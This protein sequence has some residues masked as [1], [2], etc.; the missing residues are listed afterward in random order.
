V[1]LR[2]H[3]DGVRSGSR[4]AWVP[5]ET[6]GA[7][8]VLFDAEG[9]DPSL[10]P[11]GG[12]VLF[13]VGGEDLYRK[14]F[15]GS[16][17][18]QIWL[19]HL[20]DKTFTK[21]IQRETESRTP[22]WAP[23][24]KGF[25]YVSGEGGCMNVRHRDLASGKERPVTSF[26]DD[27]VIHP[28]LSKDGR[29]M[30]FRHLF[31]FY[32]MD[33]TRPGTAPQ[34]I[35]LQPGTPAP[36]PTSRRRFYSS[37]WNNDGPGS[38]AFCDNGMQLAFTAGG[39]LWVMDTVLRNPK[40]VQGGV[41]THERDCV[42]S[43]DGHALYYFSDHGDGVALW[44]AA[45]AEPSA[46]WWENA[47]FEKTLLS[48][49]DA[50]RRNLSVSPDGR[51]LA[52]VEPRSAIV[53]ADT[54]GVV[55][56]C[57]PK[58][59]QLDAYA[60]SPDGEWIVAAMSDEYSNS[61]VWILS[62]TGQGEPYNLSRHFSWDGAPCW[63]PDGQLIAFVGVRPEKET[64]LFY[65]WLN[66]ADEDRAT[67]NKGVDDARAAMRTDKNSETGAVVRIDFDDLHRRVRRVTLPGV[68]PASP[69]FSHDSRT[70]AFEATVKGAPG[71]YTVKLPD[72]LEPKLLTAKRGRA[73][74][75]LA[76]DN[77][78]LW[79]TDNLPAHFEK[80]FG[81]SVYQETDLRDY[82]ELAY[83][84]AW[85]RLRDGFCDPG[86][87]GADWNALKEKY[88]LAARF[89]PSHSV[90]TRALLL[91]HGELNAS[92]LGFSASDTSKKEWELKESFQAW[93]SVTAHLGL[94]FDPSHAGDGWKIRDV[95]PD[96]PAAQVSL[97]LAPGDL[98][99][100]VDGVPVTAQTD[101]SAVLNGPEKRRVTLTVRTREEKPRTVS[102]PVITFAAA[103]EK[104]RDAEFQKTRAA[105]DQA[106]GG[107]FGYLNIQ[108]MQWLDYYQFEQEV[109]SEGFGKDGLIIDVRNN[110]GGFVADQ[111]LSVLCGNV[112]SIAV[113]R[114]SGPAYLA[115]Y[116]GRP[117][118]DKPIV[119]L[120]S[121]VTVSNGEIFTHAVKTLKRGKVVGTPTR[122]GVIATSDGALLDMGTL[123]IPHRGWFLLDGTD[124][125]LNG[126]QPDVLVWNT[127]DDT[128]AGRDPQ[129]EA[130]IRVMGE[131]VEA[132]KK[133][134]PPVSLN[135]AR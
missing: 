81:F 37:V 110:T 68:T 82:Q 32:R 97:R 38:V 84:T 90:F 1:I 56:A 30:V 96:T 66:R 16:N 47:S 102:L 76:K 74:A 67:F 117:V 124:M 45:R 33:P 39:D 108:K 80:T 11:E 14:G 87:H 28:A 51:R 63:S 54:N 22:L 112:H 42:F 106:S 126:A 134:H 77:R 98:V 109:F 119:V 131:E 52:W 23:D 111:I 60:W 116:W 34:R 55:T 57:G 40:L 25:Y 128:V 107:R 105:V 6:R 83:L 100:T 64:D 103:R 12:R 101:P 26:T 5:R 3:A 53:I 8:R 123:R 95:I 10:S 130:A 7:E 104:L 21:L 94:R 59:A 48:D 72:A 13:T 120:C 132:F 27:S 43:P 133:S 71:T 36:R 135:Y 4:I 127:P 46:Y 75:W 91:L 58:A 35:D 73:S 41:L 50:P 99:L 85:G 79:T 70:L 49:G 89:A 24:G 114:G 93:S 78:L 18:S 44:K 62:A 31:D 129:L 88:R 61:D 65:V 92:H 125:E 9:G 20:R 69:F 86:F 15:R 19:Y 115:G 122:G 2:D 121:E 118:Y 17:A 29:T 113:E